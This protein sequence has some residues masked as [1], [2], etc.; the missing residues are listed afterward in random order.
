VEVF[1]H[2]ELENTEDRALY[3]KW[4]L[5]EDDQ[6]GRLCYYGIWPENKGEKTCI[7]NTLSLRLHVQSQVEC[8]VLTVLQGLFESA[9]FLSTLSSHLLAMR[10][11]PPHLTVPEQPEGAVVLTA[12]AVRLFFLVIVIHCYCNP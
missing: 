8:T 3:A 11:V 9:L 5:G 1:K 12:Q 7:S 4:E 6:T 2:A 10:N